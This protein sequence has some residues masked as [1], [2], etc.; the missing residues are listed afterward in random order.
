MAAALMA[1]MIVADVLVLALHGF[2]AWPAFIIM[3]GTFLL[4][5]ACFSFSMAASARKP[6]V[7]ETALAA[8]GRLMGVTLSTVGSVMTVAHIGLLAFV[9]GILGP[10]GGEM[11]LPMFMVGLSVSLIAMY[12]RMPKMIGPHAGKGLNAFSARW[13]RT[14][15]W[16]GV[17]C[18]MVMVVV[19]IVPDFT[20]RMPVFLGLAMTPTMLTLGMTALLSFRRRRRAT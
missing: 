1:V 5:I 8:L 9:S 14:V 18:G 6:A 17:L 20:Y 3:P 7:T 19:A 11:F 16:T 12:N 2:S 15:S 13:T 10:A 4:L